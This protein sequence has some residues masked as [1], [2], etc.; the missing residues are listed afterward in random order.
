[1]YIS[2]GVVHWTATKFLAAIVPD[3]LPAHRELVIVSGAIATAAG[4]AV[5][6]P[7]TRRP[8]AWV[9][10]AWLIAVYPANLWMVQH[11][12]RYRPI[13]E[14]MLWARL[15]FQLPAVWWAWLYTRRERRFAE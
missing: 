10:V 3:Y 2:V 15:P 9:I 14:W 1:V 4:V 8:A 12:E 7:A 11:P 6:V 5:L 13:P